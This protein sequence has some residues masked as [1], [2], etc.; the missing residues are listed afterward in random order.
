[1][2][3]ALSRV[4]VVGCGAMGAGIAEVSLRAGLD[5]RVVVSSPGRI[6]PASERILRALDRA[7]AKGRMTTEERT[8]AADRLRFAVDPSELADRQLVVEAV[9]EDL[10]TKRRVFKALDA[11]VADPAAVL[12]STTSSLLVADLAEV[13]GRPE[14]VVGMH[15]FNPVP[16]MPLVEVVRSDRTGDATVDRAESFVVDLLGKEVV[17]TQDRCGFVVNALLV[18]YLMAAV[19]MYERGVASAEDIDRGMTLGCGHPMGPLALLDMIGIDTITAVARSMRENSDDLVDE[20]PPL[21]SRMVEDGRLGR[22]AGRGFFRYD[23]TAS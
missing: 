8:G 22:K 4:G 11:A 14:A 18:P 9:A 17:R 23:G 20:V 3:D 16:V 10:E 2:A 7:V 19:R 1:M 12:A 6:G 5:V 15:F 21:L 13:T